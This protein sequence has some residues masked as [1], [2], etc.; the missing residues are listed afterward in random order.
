MLTREHVTAPPEVATALARAAETLG[1]PAWRIIL[2]R[3]AV[4]AS[5]LAALFGGIWLLDTMFHV[6]EPSSWLVLII[7][8]AIL[9]IPVAVLSTGGEL[10]ASRARMAAAD[11]LR[12]DI[13]RGG[14]LRHTLDR[15]EKHWFVEHEH[16]V[17]MVCPS[18]PMGT[19]FLDFSSVA[20]DARYEEWFKTGRIHRRRWQWYSAPSGAVPTGFTAEGPE[21]PPR[22]FEKEAG[23]DDPEMAAD[24]F[25]WLGS[26]ADGE[27]IDRPFGEVDVWLRGKLAKSG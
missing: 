20:D 8:A 21:L 19:L 2:H 16:G 25:E 18:D 13:A 11:A 4:I 7:G 22:L 5:M 14:A 17:M 3:L 27:V 10:R 24:F 15:D 9:A 1:K 23:T 26:P 12:K 6:I